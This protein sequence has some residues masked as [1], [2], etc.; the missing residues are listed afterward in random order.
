MISTAL[1]S[2]AR[3]PR[4]RAIPARAAWVLGMLALAIGLILLIRSY[5]IGQRF[6]DGAEMRLWRVLLALMVLLPARP[7]SASAP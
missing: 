3:S 1:D 2:P 5:A 6:D 4:L 7:S